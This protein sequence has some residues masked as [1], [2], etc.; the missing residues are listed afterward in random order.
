MSHLKS[1]IISREGGWTRQA[2]ELSDHGEKC[3][4]FWK[5]PMCNIDAKCRTY[6]VDAAFS[7]KSIQSEC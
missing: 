7:E 4:M 5:N 3:H 1:S 6:S 2:V